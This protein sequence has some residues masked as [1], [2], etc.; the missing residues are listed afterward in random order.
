MIFL[1][2]H[3]AYDSVDSSRFLEILEG[4][5]V[6]PRTCRILRTNW[7]CLSMVAKARGCYGVSFKGTRSVTQGDPISPTIF[8]VGVHEVVRHWVT[9]MA[10]SAKDWGGRRQEGRHQ[11]YLFYVDDGM[12][13]LSAPR[14]LQGDFSTL[15]GLFYRVGLK[16]NVS[17][18]VKMIC[19][20]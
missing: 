20:P 2:L 9:V 16:Y 3:K 14:W 19:H 12:V 13:P 4:Y 8:N 11:N 10:E 7:S 6:G 17:E 18:T 1:D 5:I 15:V